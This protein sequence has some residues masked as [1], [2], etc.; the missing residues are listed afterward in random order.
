MK[1]LMSV[2]MSPTRSSMRC[3]YDDSAVAT[4]ALLAGNAS[5]AAFFHDRSISSY[6]HIWHTESE[7]FCP[8]MRNG[9]WAC[10]LNPF[11]H[12]WM[13]KDDGFCEG[14]QVRR[15]VMRMPC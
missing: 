11:F 8:R 13:F 3:R 6:K 5:D 9:T 12:K 4:L 1:P 7:Y 10:D 2:V 14:D 15:A